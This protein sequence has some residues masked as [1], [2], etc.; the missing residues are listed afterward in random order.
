MA[1]LPMSMRTDPE[2]KIEN[3]PAADRNLLMQA[4]TEFIKAHAEDARATN[5]ALRLHFTLTHSLLLTIRK[6]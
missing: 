2:L 3:L 4:L 5:K 6:P 1:D